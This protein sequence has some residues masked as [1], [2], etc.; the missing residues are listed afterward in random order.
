MAPSHLSIG[1]Q[2]ADLVAGAVF[3]KY[4]RNDNRFF[5]LIKHAFKKSEKGIIEE[6]GLIHWPK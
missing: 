6:H 3:R 5:D 1:I 4:A 2:F